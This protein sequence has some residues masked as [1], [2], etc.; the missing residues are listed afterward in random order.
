MHSSQRCDTV[1]QIDW[2]VN[3]YIPVT[4]KNVLG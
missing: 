4:A 2:Q 3:L 1:L